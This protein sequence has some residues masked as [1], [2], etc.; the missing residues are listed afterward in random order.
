MNTPPREWLAFLREQYPAGSRIKLREMK[1]PYHPVPSGTMGTL[2]NIDDAGQ[3]HVKWDNGSGLALIIGEDSFTVLPPEPTTMKLYMPLTADFYERDEWGDMSEDSEE[4]DGRTLL[5]HEGGVLTAL[6]KNRVPEE[7]K[8]GLMHWY[9]ED[10][11]VNEKVQSAVFTAEERNGRL[12]GVVECRVAGPLSPEELDTLKEYVTGQASD[13]WGEGFEQRPIEV[14]GGELD[15]GVWQAVEAVE[16]VSAEECAFHCTECLIPSLRDTIDEALEDG[17][18][19]QVNEF[20]RELA[21]K[22]RS[23]SE[24]EF[25]RY[26]A[27]LAASG[28]P[29]LGDAA[30]LLEEAEQY[31]LLPEVAE[32]WDYAELMAREKYP[33]LPSELFQTP[34]AAQIGRTMLEEGNGAITEYGLIRRTDGRPLP[35]FTGKPQREEFAGPQMTGM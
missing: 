31:E 20:A 13:A 29:S 6:V 2:E 23:W 24:A 17:G 21:Q 18:L 27:L 5:D 3:F 4:W 11:A 30:Q 34:Q 26:K 14:D 22:K 32:T 28:Q 9:G 25:V 15:K 12:W 35:V 7:S 8:R 33:D 1:D 19:A 16:A 10:D